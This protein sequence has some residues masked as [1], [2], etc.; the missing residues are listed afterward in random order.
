[1]MYNRRTVE[2]CVCVSVGGV[3][4]A[5]VPRPARQYT[6]EPQKEGPL[7][8][9]FFLPPLCVGPYSARSPCVFLLRRTLGRERDRE[10]APA[11]RFCWEASQSRVGPGR[12]QVCPCFNSPHSCRRRERVACSCVYV[13]RCFCVYFHHSGGRCLYINK[14]KRTS[15]TYL[16]KLPASSLCVCMYVCVYTWVFVCT[17][18]VEVQRQNRA[19]QTAECGCFSPVCVESPTGTVD[20]VGQHQ[21][22]KFFF[23]QWSTCFWMTRPH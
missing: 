3:G 23:H 17:R 10:R 18:I 4:E 7:F 16:F 13:F 15:N 14:D 22:L 21:T 5:A 19:K 12:S 8:F 2:D 9:L 11:G 6:S 1:M 20:I